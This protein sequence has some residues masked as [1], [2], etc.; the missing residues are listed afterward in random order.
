[1]GIFKTYSTN[2]GKS[3][4]HVFII[5]GDRKKIQKN[6]PTWNLVKKR[7]PKLEISEI[8]GQVHGFALVNVPKI[9][10]PLVMIT[11]LICDYSVDIWVDLQRLLVFEGIL[12]LHI[13]WR[14]P[15]RAW[16]LRKPNSRAHCIPKGFQMCSYAST[17]CH[18]RICSG[19]GLD[20]SGLLFQN[21]PQRISPYDMEKWV[22]QKTK[23]QSI[24]YPK[25]IP[26]VFIWISISINRDYFE[27]VE[28][29]L[30]SFG[31]FCQSG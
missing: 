10:K 20:V 30:G 14:N 2:I 21:A 1:M 17:I 28:A 7:V 6:A 4:P 23:F 19:V 16:R 11:H 31:F 26:N 27:Y 15:P 12:F 3:I 24:S 18:N 22:F 9:S 5:L 25:T 29:M 8:L 13:I